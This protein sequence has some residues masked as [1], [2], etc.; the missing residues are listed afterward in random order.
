MRRIGLKKS[1]ITYINGTNIDS[2]SSNFN[3][4]GKSFNILPFCSCYSAVRLHS[5][6]DHIINAWLNLSLN[7]EGKNAHK[8][9][10][11]ALEAFHIPNSTTGIQPDGRWI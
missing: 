3:P 10:Y 6:Y 4:P 11:S 8:D 7:D 5:E 9:Y 1:Y 2:L